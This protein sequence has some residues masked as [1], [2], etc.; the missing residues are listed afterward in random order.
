M[1]AQRR[2]VYPSKENYVHYLGEVIKIG[3]KNTVF[4]DY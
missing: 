2:D 4:G 3:W 1:A